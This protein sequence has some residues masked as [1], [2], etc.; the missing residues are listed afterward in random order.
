MAEGKVLIVED[1]PINMELAQD[2]LEVRGFEVLT[3]TS[4]EEGLHVA[5]SEL[6]DIVLMDISLP[7]MDGL[8]AIRRLKQEPDTRPI[9]VVCMTAHAMEGDMEMAMQAGAAGY[10]TKPINTREF[11]NQV[12]LHLKKQ[13][14]G[15]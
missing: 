3:A 15:D 10:I 1:N 2:L 13:P 8:E 7:A 6:P 11:A 9:P 12:T 5:H 4:A 14:Q